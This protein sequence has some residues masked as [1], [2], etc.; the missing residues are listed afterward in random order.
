MVNAEAFWDRIA[1]K[2]A[3]SPIKNMDSYEYT[4]GRTCSYL[5]STDRVLEIGAGTGSTALLLADSVEEIIATDISDKMLDVGRIKVKEQAVENVKFQRA[6]SGTLPE[7]PFDAV[8]AHNVLHLV[9]DLPGTLKASYDALR[10]S[11]LLISKTFL[12]PTKG[13]QP[14]YRVMKL[15]LPLM[16][17]IG[18][19]PFVA[20]Y[21]LEEFERII[22]R[23]GFEIIET[24]NYPAK[25]GRRYIVARKR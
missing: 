19:A 3:K 17:M 10:P 18:K 13:L 12:R 5:K 20:I 21:K 23:A 4:L 11:G 2:Y 14:V 25:E 6:D 16:Q 15:I 8:L 1:P 7:G 24:A 9:E 22:E